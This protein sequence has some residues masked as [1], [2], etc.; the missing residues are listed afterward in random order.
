MHEQ[1]RNPHPLPVEESPLPAALAKRILCPC[2]GAITNLR[3]TEGPNVGLFSSARVMSMESIAYGNWW[4]R[5]RDSNPRYGCPYD[6]LA[7]RWFQP[8]THVSGNHGSGGCSEPFGVVQPPLSRRSKFVPKAPICIADHWEADP[9]INV[10]PQHAPTQL[11]PA[12][13]CRCI[14]RQSSAL[15]LSGRASPGG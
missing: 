15:D 8:L 6:A 11:C 4:R 10:V 14:C 1:R 5:R 13:G 9:R 3:A 2:L 7:K 12:V